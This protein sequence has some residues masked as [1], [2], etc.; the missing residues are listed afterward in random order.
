MSGA[1]M[2]I[3]LHQAYQ[4]H[5]NANSKGRLTFEERWSGIFAYWISVLEF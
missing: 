5:K 4:E 2:Y 3:L 1:V